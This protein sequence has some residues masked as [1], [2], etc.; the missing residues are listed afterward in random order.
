[1]KFRE[2]RAMVAA[3]ARAAADEPAAVPAAEAMTAQQAWRAG[4]DA[5]RKQWCESCC[6]PADDCQCLDMRRWYWMNN[7]QMGSLAGDDGGSHVM[8]R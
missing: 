4:M 7:W 2:R 3:A 8:D 1:M 5:N 6:C